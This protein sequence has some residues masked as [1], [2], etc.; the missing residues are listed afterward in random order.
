[1]KY[2]VFFI[3]CFWPQ[4]PW[5]Y[6]ILSEFALFLTSWKKFKITTQK[7]IIK[8]TN[9][10]LQN[11]FSDLLFEQRAWLAFCDHCI[12]LWMAYIL[13][14]IIFHSLLFLMIKLKSLSSFTQNTFII[15]FLKHRI[16]IVILKCLPN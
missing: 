14:I 1:M 4:C 15:Y 9:E 6:K 11:R 7:R 12:K 13:M 16:K 8:Y 5:V 2:R 10:T 3:F